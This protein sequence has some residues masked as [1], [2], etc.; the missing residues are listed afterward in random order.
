M[1][2]LIILLAA[3]GALCAQVQVRYS[4]TTGDVVLGGTGTTLTIQP[5]PTSTNNQK[6][7]TGEIA[8]VYCS[9]ACSVTH[10]KNGAAATATAGTFVAINPGEFTP[11]V[12]TVWT[13]S[14]VG[15]GTGV[16]GITHIP[17]GQTIPI[18]LSKVTLGNTGTATNYS[19]IVSSITGT[20][21]ITVIGKEQ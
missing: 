20:A 14:N 11:P 6:L 21:N 15:A 5:P 9:V 19:L 4:A 8:L 12:Y 10:A 1:K 18:D 13:A 16:S 2:T 3:A 7:W 17:A